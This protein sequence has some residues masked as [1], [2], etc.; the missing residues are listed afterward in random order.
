MPLAA[1]L[2]LWVLGYP[3]RAGVRSRAVSHDNRNSDARTPMNCVLLYC[4]DLDNWQK[5]AGKIERR[6]LQAV[7]RQRPMVLHVLVCLLLFVVLVPLSLASAAAWKA[8]RSPLA[9]PRTPVRKAPRTNR[10]FVRK[11]ASRTVN[12]LAPEMVLPRRA[13]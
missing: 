1:S 7:W 12:S 9:Q 4:A 6:Y 2:A 3:A 13:R 10:R 5:V 8:M 11:H